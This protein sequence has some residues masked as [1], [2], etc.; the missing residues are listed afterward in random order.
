MG[1]VNVAV[2]QFAEYATEGDIKLGSLIKTGLGMGAVTVGIMALNKVM[3]V[4]A[5]NKA[6]AQAR[7]ES[8]TKA[9][10]AEEDGLKGAVAA[11]A[12]KSLSDRG[13]IDQARQLG[14]TTEDLTEAIQGRATP[15][16]KALTDQYGYLAISI[17]QLRR[18]QTDTERTAEAL[19]RQVNIQTHAF[20]DAERAT[21]KTAKTS[22][23]LKDRQIAAAEVMDRQLQ[24]AIMAVTDELIGQYNALVAID[25]KNRESQDA[26]FA[27][28]R[29]ELRAKDQFKETSEAI[30]DKAK[31]MDEKKQ[32]VIDYAT[33]TLDLKDKQAAVNGEM[34]SAPEAVAAQTEALEGLKKGVKDPRALA[35]FIG[36]KKYGAKKFNKAAAEGK[37]L[38]GSKPK[39][40]Q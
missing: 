18:G 40:V 2:G 16:W 9:L 35:A 5:A 17:E 4:F 3:D 10:K 33:A 38:K 32:S 29:E 14:L 24:P 19:I 21:Y 37:S 26:V 12:E 27:L 20:N 8:F 39:G 30:K 28:A 34:L 22:A 15:A 7:V 6:A 13:M 11:A 23:D 1:A 36:R 25:E 31:T